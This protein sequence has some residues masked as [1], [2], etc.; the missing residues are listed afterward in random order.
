MKSAQQGFTLIELMIVVSIIGIMTSI[1]IPTY[2]DYTIRT[3]MTEVILAA[4]PCRTMITEMYLV[5]SGSP[6][7][8]NWGCEDSSSALITAIDTN[9]NGGIRITISSALGSHLA[10][11][12]VLLIP[13]NN[14]GTAMEWGDSGRIQRWDCGPG[15]IWSKYLPSSCRALTLTF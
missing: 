13:I 7:A 12:T 14:T 8:G 11:D 9:A 2:Q 1:V 3:K 4:S 10:G 5:G 6:G 15:T